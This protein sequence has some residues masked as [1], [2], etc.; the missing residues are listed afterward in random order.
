MSRP[1]QVFAGSFY[2][3]T[4]RCTQRQ[5]LLR[6][7]EITN[8]TFLYCLIEAAIRYGV[9]ILLPLAEA[10]HHHTV[11]YDPNGRAPQF[12]EHFHKMVARCMN[13]RWGRCENLWAAGEVCLT[14][15][16]TR[17]AVID[18]LV[19]TASNPVKDLLV[20]KAL[21]WPGANGYCNWVSGE[22]LRA[23]RPSHFFRDDG[24]MPSTVELPLFIPPQLG[25]RDAVIAEVKARVEAVEKSVRA[26][27]LESGKRVLGRKQVL[28]QSWRASPK[29]VEPR[30]ALRPR[31]AGSGAARAAALIAYRQFLADYASARRSW[32]AGLLAVFPPGTYWLS[33]CAAV[34][35]APAPPM[36]LA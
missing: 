1:R 10:N 24:E 30:R 26:A 25:P 15:L 36:T 4:R 3:L 14:R 22:P 34:S 7:D 5:F 29:T 8:N 16:L 6:P 33:R 17:E 20:D 31:F 23:V 21:Q 11:L 13:A 12:V 18:E 27:R 2:L 32:L 28:A 9:D 35:V 19:Y